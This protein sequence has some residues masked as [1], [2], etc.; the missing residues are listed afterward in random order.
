MWGMDGQD[1]PR[2]NS[3]NGRNIPPPGHVCNSNFLGIIDNNI[4]GRDRTG[5]QKCREWKPPMLI[6][7][8]TNTPERDTLPIHSCQCGKQNRFWISVGIEG[9]VRSSTGYAAQPEG[10]GL[11]IGV[12]IDL[13]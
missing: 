4:S 12:F 11:D 13:A 2:H 1:G 7:D 3:G 10:V 6:L 8:L 5:P 9:K